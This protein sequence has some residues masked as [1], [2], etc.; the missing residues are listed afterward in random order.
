MTKEAPRT[1]SKLPGQG[2]NTAEVWNTEDRPIKTNPNN[3]DRNE[4]P[5]RPPRNRKSDNLF[6]NL[7]SK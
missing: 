6:V 4:T 7:L 1:G 2:V 3:S 5:I